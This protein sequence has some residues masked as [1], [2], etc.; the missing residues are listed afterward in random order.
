H[1]CLVYVDG[2]LAAT[3][4]REPGLFVEL[5]RSLGNQLVELVSLHRRPTQLFLTHHTDL[6]DYALVFFDGKHGVADHALA[7]LQDL[8]RPAIALPL[9]D[10]FGRYRKS[11]ELLTYPQIFGFRYV[12]AEHEVDVLH[13]IRFGMK[14]DSHEITPSMRMRG[15]AMTRAVV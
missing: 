5:E 2:Q 7:V 3:I 8:V 10:A 14:L 6:L 13:A 9:Q 1:L 4:D 11:T 15:G 12:L